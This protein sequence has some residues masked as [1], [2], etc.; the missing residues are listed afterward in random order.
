MEFSA[1]ILTRQVVNLFEWILARRGHKRQLR[2]RLRKAKTYEE[3]IKIA[4]ELDQYMGFDDWKE[5]GDDG[6]FDYTLVGPTS[7]LC[8]RIANRVGQE[9]QEDPAQDEGC[10]RHQGIDGHFGSLCKEQFRRYRII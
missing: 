5:N 4:K 8:W 6:Y 10:K 1:Y 7:C 9:S 3:W 2:L